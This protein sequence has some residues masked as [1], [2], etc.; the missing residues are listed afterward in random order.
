MQLIYSTCCNA[1]C[2]D[3]D[4]DSLKHFP[5]LIHI[6]VKKVVLGQDNTFGVGRSGK[7]IPG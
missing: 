3:N 1:E 2:T 4:S 7:R 5:L 6:N